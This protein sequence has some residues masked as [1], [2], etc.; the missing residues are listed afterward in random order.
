MMEKSLKYAFA[1]VGGITGYTVTRFAFLSMGLNP[2][3]FSG[4]CVI[5][6]VAVAFGILMLVIGAKTVSF[7]V[8]AVEKAEK[9]LMSL[10]LYELMICAGG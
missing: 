10:T 8:I 2:Y 1:I 3:S 7:A 4:I 5:V 9:V 6:I